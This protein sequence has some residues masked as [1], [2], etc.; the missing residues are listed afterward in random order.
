MVE[1]CWSCSGLYLWSSSC[2]SFNKFDIK[3]ISGFSSEWPSFYVFKCSM[4]SIAYYSLVDSLLILSIWSLL[5]FKDASLTVL[6]FCKSWFKF[7]FFR[8]I[9]LIV[10]FWF[11]RYSW[12]FWAFSS[13]SFLRGVEDDSTCWI[14]LTKL[15][16]EGL[17]SSA[18]DRLPSWLKPPSRSWTSS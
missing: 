10:I 13:I 11:W 14:C 7:L 4:S 1:V 2:F 18:R 3:F 16:T 9:L 8:W 12:S 6:T 5:Y 15:V 17:V